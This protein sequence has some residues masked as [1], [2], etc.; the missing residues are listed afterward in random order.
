MA[1]W[2]PDEMKQIA[3]SDLVLPDP[4]LVC[5]L[6]GH[7][8]Q[9]LKCVSVRGCRVRLLGTHT[10]SKGQCRIPQLGFGDRDGLGPDSAASRLV[11]SAL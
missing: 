2:Q 6:Q 5:S 3:A 8:L 11:A 10:V 4:G 9:T 7:D 1:A